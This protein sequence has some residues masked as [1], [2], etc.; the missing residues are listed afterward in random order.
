MAGGV[1]EELC[2]WAKLCIHLIVYTNCGQL[3][4][5]VT[6]YSLLRSAV[7]ESV[8]VAN[9]LVCYGGCRHPAWNIKRPVGQGCYFP[10]T[11]LGALTMLLGSA[12]PLSPGCKTEKGEKILLLVETFLEVVFLISKLYLLK[13]PKAFQENK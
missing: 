12:E 5:S 7:R 1:R 6:T 8:C 11:L 4:Y 2:V 3:N 9:Q 13:T 10:P